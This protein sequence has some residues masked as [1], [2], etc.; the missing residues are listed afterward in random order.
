MCV[1]RERERESER[2]RERKRE[3]VWLR[4]TV[5]AIPIPKLKKKFG[6]IISIFG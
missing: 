4:N 3:E 5:R 2:E 1:Q 6:N